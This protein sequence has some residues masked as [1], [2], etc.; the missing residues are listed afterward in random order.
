MAIA[1][2]VDDRESCTRTGQR[3]HIGW[4]G[5][6]C[7]IPS[8]IGN[9]RSL[10]STRDRTIGVYTF[11]IFYCQTEDAERHKTALIM[12]KLCFVISM[13]LCGIIG[14][15]QNNSLQPAQ[16][17][18]Y[19][20]FVRNVQGQQLWQLMGVASN[21]TVT[22]LFFNI[23]VLSKEPGGFIF[24]PSIYISGD[25]GTMNPIGLRVADNDFPLGKIWQYPKGNKGKSANCVLFFNRIPAGVTTINYCEPNFINWKDIP[26]EDNPN[27]TEQTQ[28]TDVIL[29]EYWTQNKCSNIEGIYYFTNT[30][31]K[32]W[33]GTIKHTFA[34]IK[35][36]YEY[37]LIYLKGGN[38]KIWHEGEVKAVFIP[39]ATAGLYKVT[40]WYME[41]KM[42]NED[43][44]I[45]FK[46]GNMSVYEN[47]S[48]VTADFLKLFPAIDANDFED[49]SRS[50]SSTSATKRS[51]DN[52][53][54]ASGS[55]VF[56]SSNVIAT[57]YHL[58]DGA[59][60]I[61]ISIKNGN[62]VQTFPAKVLCSDKT[63]DLALLTIEDE[64]FSGMPTIPYSISS[65]SREVGT[66]IIAMGYPMANYMGDE[67]KITDGIIS[68][69]TGYEGD[70]VTY[71]ISAPI[72]PGNSG[73]PLFDKKG[74][75]IGITNAGIAAAQNVGYAI[76]SS[77]LCNLMESAPIDIAI[78]DNPSLEGKELTDQIK[79]ISKFVVFIKIH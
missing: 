28:W 61:D 25:F 69:R 75:L 76:K 52:T 42:T 19:S 4:C 8:T 78:P 77:Y 47:T 15:S 68:S 70:I 16:N 2:H 27:T 46:E 10:K 34:V 59:S 62:S 72:Q 24:P 13:F 51:S 22:A 7:F 6:Y 21:E 66:S 63:N 20:S 35:D 9:A 79:E 73:G 56:V 38:P 12:K 18:D 53:I 45:T 31:N 3:F 36:G 41:N 5:C 14:W 49:H 55:G 33:W 60:K 29:R 26:V 65:K 74:N 40:T 32:D 1:P 37:K 17:A 54:T 71:Q 39:T 48:N 50:K 57:N 43:F 67:V 11:F 64:K 58:I 44:Y 23:S 30:T